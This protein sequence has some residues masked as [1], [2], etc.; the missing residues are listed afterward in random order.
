LAKPNDRVEL[1]P[2]YRYQRLELTHY[3][4]EQRWLVIYSDGAYQ[5][6]SGDPGQSRA[7]GTS[8][9]KEGPVPFGYLKYKK[10]EFVL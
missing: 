3:G 7:K 4:I 8:A 2:G 9:P 1:S 5:R 10:Y 6:A